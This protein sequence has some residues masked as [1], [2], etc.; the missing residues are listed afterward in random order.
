MKLLH[1]ADWHVGKVLKG[2]SRLDEQ[3]AVLAEIVEVARAEQVDLVVVAGDVF[4]TSVPGADAQQVAWHTLLALRA[5]GAAVVVVA[6]NHDPA[7]AFD[8]LRPVFAGLGITLLGR[9]RRPDDGGVVELTTTG[10]ERVRLALLPF[11]SQRGVVK[12]AD[13]MAID[14]AQLAGEYAARLTAVLAALTGSFDATAVNVVVAHATVRG[15][16]LGG[17]ERDAQTVFDYTV[18]ATAFP[19]T[20][21]YAALG[22]LHRTQ[23]LPA[24]CPLWYSGS[25]IAVDFGEQADPKHV[26]LVE[27]GPGLPAKVR[28]H[29]LGAPR[30]LRTVKGTVAQLAAMAGEVGDDLLR[31]VVTEPARAGLAGEVRAVLPNALDIRVE[32]ADDGDSPR[33]GVAG[34]DG[35]HVGRSPHELFA[36][37]LAHRGMEDPRVQVLFAELLDAELAERAP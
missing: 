15:G 27:A 35:G 34:V 26:L 10:G 1:T 5:T 24:A 17:G 36:A 14:A 7:D 12:A 33:V 4:E 18:P 8:A 32:R 21:T 11:V 2:V 28:R 20:T 25:P 13:L 30:G 31:V 9:P 19:P 37:F 22:H 6:G 29:M 16:V 3:R 23:D